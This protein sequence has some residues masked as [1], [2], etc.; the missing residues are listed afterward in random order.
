MKATKIWIDFV[1][2][3]GN[4]PYFIVE[5]DE[6]PDSKKY[7][8]ER[9]EV[10][11]QGGNIYFS[12]QE[13][14]VSYLFEDLRDHSGFGGR[15]FDLHLKDGSWRRLDGPW[16][17]RAGI[18]NGLNY[19]PKIVDVT[20]IASNRGMGTGRFAGHV[21]KEWLDAALEGEKSVFVT[22]LEPAWTKEETYFPSFKG[23][24]PKASKDQAR[25]DLH[26]VA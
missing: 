5:V 8:Y 20:I 19:F 23:M 17:S 11:E 4:T 14:C 24:T 6:L 7:L 13:G 22:A 15:P 26:P 18:V 3:R 12:E 9:Y 25:A 10:P 21:T 2:G 16:S 1:L